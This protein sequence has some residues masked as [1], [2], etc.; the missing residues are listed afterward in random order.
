MDIIHELKQ[1]STHYGLSL[2]YGVSRT[3]ITK[4][5]S[6]QEQVRIEKM[7]STNSERKMQK[8]DRKPKYQE[9]E[10]ELMDWFAEKGVKSKY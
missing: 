2:K 1:G 4:I 3:Q 5:G 7:C 9:L 10:S 8:R 6:A